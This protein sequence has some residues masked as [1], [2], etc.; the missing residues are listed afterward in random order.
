MSIYVDKLPLKLSEIVNKYSEEVKEKVEKIL[1]ETAE[2]TLE[3]IKTN[4]V[5]SS[6]GNNHL[7]DSFILTIVGSGSS[8][9]IFIS[10]KSKGRLVHLIEL[11]FKHRGG[12]FVPA[13]PFM[14][15]AFDTFSPKM[16]E[17][18]R[19]IIEKGGL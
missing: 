2:E 4:C 17:E 1:D 9:T 16:L 3:Y 12:K 8:K 13:R 5:K 11:G 7:A 18:I 6:Y 19:G 15:P 10:S 14:R